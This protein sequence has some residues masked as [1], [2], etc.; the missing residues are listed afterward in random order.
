ME[1][2]SYAVAKYT[3][4]LLR[5]EPRNI[6]VFVSSTDRVVARFL[7]ETQPGVLTT[8]LLPK[9]L[10]NDP[11]LYGEW[12]D[13]WRRTLRRLANLESGVS[14][15]EVIQQ[16]LIKNEGHAFAVARG[17]EFDPEPDQTLEDVVEYLFTRLVIPK[18]ELTMPDEEAQAIGAPGKSGP[19]V[20]RIR[21]EFKRLGILEGHR[22]G[23]RTNANLFVK[24]PVRVDV[25]VF[26]INP[27]PHV[28]DFVQTNGCRYVM[29]QID[30]SIQ[31]LLRA[32][33]HAMHS[34]YILSDIAEAAQTRPDTSGRVKPIAIVNRTT[35]QVHD[36]QDYVE[37]AL[38]NIPGI[39]M[40]RWDRPEEQR[41]FLEERRSI[42]EVTT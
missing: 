40:I 39:E 20:R 22:K 28:P 8:S 12:H 3:P 38:S 14:V 36:I 27:I 37:A 33:D 7:G 6:G 18:A 35:Q 1:R 13:Y 11:D 5:Q 19:L 21:S 17:G 34:Q 24:H 4:D 23:Q 42:A 41:R 30:F 15:L 26:G 32:R 2:L 31:T 29:E 16:K 25:P 9:D 10:F